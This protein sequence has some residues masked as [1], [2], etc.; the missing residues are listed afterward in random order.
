MKTT[1]YYFSGTGNSLSAARKIASLLGDSD[2]IPIAS[3]MNQS[4]AVI[5]PEGR[6]G[7]ICPVY[8]MGVPVLVT[9]F[10]SRL[11]VHQGAYVFALITLGGTGAAALKMINTGLLQHSGRGLDAGFLVKMPGN[12]PPVS[13]PPTG[14]KRATIL[15]EAEATL[16]DIGKKIQE[17]SSHPLGFTPVS[18]LLQQLLYGG[19][20]RGVRSGDEKFT[21]SEACTSCGICVS[22]CPTSN[23]TLSEGRP[24]WN[25]HCELCC[26]CLNYCPTQAID[27]QMMFGTK[28]RGRYHHP[29]IT[30]ADMQA[31]KGNRE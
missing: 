8:D 15:K 12:F 16:E 27:L 29:G 11:R 10:L 5:A 14:D 7:I 2:L 3:L 22:V 28:G 6:I 26:G 31:Q 21:V 4:G 20:A 30:I 9:E 25:H 17:G 24:V 1:I 13:P 23:I 18:S 19:F